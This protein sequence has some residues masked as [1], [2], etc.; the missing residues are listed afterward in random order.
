VGQRAVVR[1]E[2]FAGRTFGGEVTEVSMSPVVPDGA[3]EGVVN[4]L[5]K[6]GFDDTVPGMLPGMTAFADIITARSDSALMVPIQS[7]LTRQ[8]EQLA[9]QFRPEDAPAG[10][11]VQAVFVLENGAAYLVPVQTGIAGTDHIE[12][13][14]GLQRGQTV[15]TGPFGV[16][17]DLQSGTAVRG[18]P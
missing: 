7:V 13:S 9:P 15:I 16:I 1:V 12:I 17:R 2:A 18:R 11:E 10:T 8:V 4:Y 5:V 14:A 3:A 6:V